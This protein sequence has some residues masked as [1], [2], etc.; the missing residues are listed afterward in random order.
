MHIS[1]IGIVVNGLSILNKQYKVKKKGFDLTANA[2]LRNSLLDA[3]LRMTQVL[4]NEDIHYFKFKKYRL[5][6]LSRKVN[7]KLNSN[8]DP[9][10]EDEEKYSDIVF[11]A[12][13]DKEIPPK[14][15][16]GYL[17]NI[18]TEFLIKYPDIADSFS[19]D[20]RAFAEFSPIFDEILSDL[21]DTA[22]ERFGDFF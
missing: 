7:S 11:Y 20:I 3:I 5:V 9:N 14:T 2:D 18:C 13:G 1:E 21:T 10:I 16:E 22:E 17:E 6:L 12:I 15:I 8:S 19:G 4:M